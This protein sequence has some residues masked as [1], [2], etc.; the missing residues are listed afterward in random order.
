MEVYDSLGP[1]PR[2]VGMFML[3]KGLNV[4]AQQID[5]MGGEN[6]RSPTSPSTA[7]STSA[8]APARR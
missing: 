6:R 3:E 1:K 4:P 8:R 5:I 2:L 7:W